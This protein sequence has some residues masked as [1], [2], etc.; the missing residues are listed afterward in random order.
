MRRLARW[1]LRAGSS[2]FSVPVWTDAGRRF[3]KK[4][5]F[6]KNVMGEF[7]LQLKDAE[8][9]LNSTR[10]ARVALDLAPD[11]AM[12]TDNTDGDDCDSVV[13]IQ[14]S[15]C[16]QA[17]DEQEGNSCGP[18]AV[19]NALLALGN[20]YAT[21]IDM[22]RIDVPSEWIDT[23][24]AAA[25]LAMYDPL[26]LVRSHV[27]HLEMLGQL[28]PSA[29]DTWQFGVDPIVAM[30]L[31]AVFKNMEPD[32]RRGQVPNKVL[33]LT[34]TQEKWDWKSLSHFICLEI[35]WEISDRENNPRLDICVMDSSEEQRKVHGAEVI[36]AV[37]HLRNLLVPTVQSLRQCM[38]PRI[39]A[40]P[41]LQTGAPSK[42]LDSQS[43]TA[44]C[45]E[46]PSPSHVGNGGGSTK[47]LTVAPLAA[48]TTFTGPKG[49][50]TMCERGEFASDFSTN[51][52][53]MSV[54][55]AAPTVVSE[56][57]LQSQGSSSSMTSSFS[58]D[59]VVDGETSSPGP[60]DHCQSP[61]CTEFSDREYPDRPSPTPLEP[62]PVSEDDDSWLTRVEMELS[63]PESEASGPG[64]DVDPEFECESESETS[65]VT[66]RATRNFQHN[67]TINDLE[68]VQTPIRK[69]AS[70]SRRARASA[71]SRVPG[72]PSRSSDAV[73]ETQLSMSDSDDHEDEERTRERR[74]L[75]QDVDRLSASSSKR[76]KVNTGLRGSGALHASGY[77]HVDHRLD[78]RRKGKPSV[79]KGVKRLQEKY[80][81]W[82]IEAV[83]EHST[84]LKIQERGQPRT[85]SVSVNRAAKAMQMLEY[86]ECVNAL[87]PEHCS[88][89]K[90]CYSKLKPAD[91]LGLR[92]ET[93]ELNAD[94]NSVT[95]WLVTR[96]RAVGTEEAGFPFMVFGH[97]VCGSFYARAHGVGRNKALLARTLAATGA[98]PAPRKRGIVASSS[99]SIC[100]THTD[101]TPDQVAKGVICAAFWEEFIGIFS[102]KPNDHTRLYPVDMTKDGIYEQCF[103]PWFKR[104]VE[105]GRSHTHTHTHTHTHMFLGIHGTRRAALAPSRRCSMTT[106]GLKM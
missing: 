95:D 70:E 91:V 100:D 103:E 72:R 34:T 31:E 84:Y 37:N 45:E 41:A 26:G 87:L 57:R 24:L 47:V 3:Y 8:N 4:C 101:T 55:S 36:K 49:V 106:Q 75:L 51:D 28:K 7:V 92:G 53:A 83:G 68:D 80:P 17:C 5:G 63:G 32:N 97:E 94:E 9:V 21:E 38:L 54:N 89:S 88:C 86:R 29:L 18:H 2:T 85:F 99:D 62:S 35:S 13:E 20:G 73:S 12:D 59:D 50:L 67:V 46:A 1:Y 48:A 64:S 15:V 74:R 82:T 90:R 79:R 14:G 42:N 23:Q 30:M 76:R 25:A 58:F 11:L 96:L 66:G 93:Y 16:F 43:T 19:R 102:Q 104:Q 98:R 69:S 40:G 77:R 71:R 52:D 105:A 22:S 56:S 10:R 27:L 33:V 81:T 65:V 61:L 60:V 44:G 6:K 39:M 78:K